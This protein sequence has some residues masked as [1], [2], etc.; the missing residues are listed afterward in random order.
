[1]E[2]MSGLDA[3]FL[4]TETASAH[5][6]TIKVA[7]VDVAARPELLTPEMFLGLLEE[8]LDRMPVLRRRVVM[9]PHGLGAPL[10]V[11]DPDFALERHVRV[12]VAAPPGGD[13]ELADIVADV[14]A[15]ALPRDRP[16]WELTVVQGLEHERMAFVAKLHHSLAD[17]VA[18]VAM[19]MNA[20]MSED[21]VL[22]TYRPEPVPTRRQLYRAAAGSW[23]RGIAAFPDFVHRTGAG[24]KR[25]RRARRLE[26]VPVLGPF[27]GARTPLNVPLTPGRTFGM[28]RLPMADLLAARAAF[29]VSLNDVFLGVCAGGLRRHLA[30]TAGLPATSLVASVPVAT[31]TDQHRLSGNHVDNLF[32]PIHTEIA[33]PVRRLAAI[34][35]S[36]ASARRVRAAFG[37]EL[38]ELRSGFLPP[39]MLAAGTRLVTW[40]RVAAHIRP[41]LNLVASNVAGPR[42]PLGLDGGVITALYSVGPILEGIGLNITAWSYVDTMYVSLLGCPESLPDPFALADD[43]RAALAEISE[44]V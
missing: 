32:L 19:L 44:R 8:R 6:H 27:A 42:E 4:H 2:E 9:V 21:A 29:G 18:S 25:A 22:E 35:E 30:R 23:A 41:P 17:G 1:M 11:D 34:H 10:I 40:S 39:T 15:E 37:P 43:L 12:R 36:T 31:R 7:V 26:E 16:L 33:D 5:M 28:V 13:R 38:F 3:R 20:F 24:I 14:A